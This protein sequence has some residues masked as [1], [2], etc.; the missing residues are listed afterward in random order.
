MLDNDNWPLTDTFISC[1]PN[2]VINR[3]QPCAHSL[4]VSYVTLPLS[5]TL[6]HS[7]Y[8]CLN[9]CHL[10]Y[11]IISCFL[12]LF[13][14]NPTL[15][16]VVTSEEWSSFALFRLTSLYGNLISPIILYILWECYQ[17]LPFSSNM[18][19]SSALNNK[20]ALDLEH[21]SRHSPILSLH[22]QNSKKPSEPHHP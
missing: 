18:F 20:V 4:T 10:H 15:S 21:F 8:S 5:W 13:F 22:W 7:H 9:F 17:L 2:R 19:V 14:L 1:L 16:F 6:R 3:L 11:N 12:L